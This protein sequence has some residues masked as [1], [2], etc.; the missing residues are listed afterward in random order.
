[1]KQS[2]VHSDDA[3]NTESA[4]SLGGGR[5]VWD[6]GG[7]G[8]GGPPAGGGRQWL[9]GGGRGGGGG[10]AGGAVAA[11]WRERGNFLKAGRSGRRLR[12]LL[13]RWTSL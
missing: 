10:L 2:H 4:F 7:Q 6:H 13:L 1:M 3:V 8:Q 9:G 11:A 12:R 5:G